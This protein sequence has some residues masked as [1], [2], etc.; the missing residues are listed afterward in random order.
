MTK[1]AVYVFV[2]LILCG[3][4][5]IFPGGCK[6]QEPAKLTI[7]V[8][9]KE[10]SDAQIF[11][12]EM[13]VGSLTQTIVMSDGKVYIN[14][15]IAAKLPHQKDN[16]GVDSYSG[17][18]DAMHLPS[19]RHTITLRTDEVEPLK[20]IV[21]ISPGHHLLTILPEKGMVKWDNTSLQIGPGRSVII[22]PEKIK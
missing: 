9:G 11:I 17:C 3:A 19:G 15:I 1:S 6:Q 16:Q 14:G 10:L 7:A 13:L 5:T 18:S 22:A 2:S 20:V 4:L 8:E 21:N 12:N